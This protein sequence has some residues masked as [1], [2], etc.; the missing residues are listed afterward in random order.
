MNNPADDLSTPYCAGNPPAGFVKL[1]DH[2]AVPIYRFHLVRSGDPA[3]AEGRTAQTFYRARAFLADWTGRTRPDEPWLWSLALHTHD[4]ALRTAQMAA[5]RWEPSG[6]AAS[7]SELLRLQHALIP[8][9]ALAFERL[10][11]R[12]ADILALRLFGGL[13]AA[14]TAAVLGRSAQQ[15]ERSSQ[16][17]LAGL[18][19]SLAPERAQELA[20]D[21][22][23]LEAELLGLVERI[24]P[25]PAF[26]AALSGELRQPL[27]ARSPR[28]KPAARR[29]LP[30]GRS[31]RGYIW[32]PLVVAGV[33]LFVANIWSSPAR[34]GSTPPPTLAR[35]SNQTPR[36]IPVT[37]GFLEPASPAACQE[38]QGALEDTLH[39]KTDL[40]LESPF[41]DPIG[42]GEDRNG[43][44]C[45]IRASGS[46]S[47]F[48]GIDQTI[49]TI[50]PL[51]VG[52]GYQVDGQFGA[53]PACP[54]CFQFPNDVDG[55]GLLLDK[56]DGRAILAI[57]WR[58]DDVNLCPNGVSQKSCPLPP[59]AQTYSLRLD[60][61][62]DPARQALMTFF[63]R[64]QAGNTA[65]MDYLSEDLHHRVTSLAELNTLAGIPQSQL[66]A[67]EV[68]WRIR[69][70]SGEA[71]QLFVT[72]HSPQGTA[73]VFGRPLSRLAISMT[74]AAGS[75][76]IQDIWR[77]DLYQRSSDTAFIADAQGRIL[78]LSIDDGTVVPLTDANFYRPRPP[79]AG[80]SS[81]ASLVRLSPDG[82]WLAISTPTFAPENPDL[83]PT[84]A[85]TWLLSTGGGGPRQINAHP[86]RMAWSPQ[87]QMIAYISPSDAQAIY[88]YDVTTGGN[89]VLTRVGGQI[90][91]MAWSPNGKQL[92]VTYPMPAPAPGTN[93]PPGIDL[94]VLSV[95]SGGEDLMVEFPGADQSLPADPDLELSWTTSSSEV[96][97][98]PGKVAVNVDTHTVEPLVAQ[99]GSAFQFFQPSS[100]L[101]PAHGMTLLAPDETL[102]ANSYHGADPGGPSWV[103][104]HSLAVDPESSVAKAVIRHFGAV[105]AL[106][107][108]SDSRS[109]VVAGGATAPQPVWRMDSISGDLY[110]LTH[111][112]YFIGLRSDLQRRSLHL[113]PQAQVVN[114]AGD[115][116]NRVHRQVDFPFFHLRLEVPPGWQVTQPENA[117]GQGQISSIGFQDPLG[118]TSLEN[119]QMMI[120][121]SR[122]PLGVDLWDPAQKMM[123][124]SAGSSVWPIWEPFQVGGYPAFWL[125]HPLQTGG[126]L[127]I[128]IPLTDQ[129]ITI[130]KYPFNSLL[131]PQFE[132]ILKSITFY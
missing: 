85:G 35:A 80:S 125:T 13:T 27:P 54:T 129:T 63:Q 69:G 53:N 52:R 22:R 116:D 34:R 101:S 5:E 39:V 84:P 103:E 40:A 62:L 75:W 2:L 70:G 106:A 31:L 100:A 131:D 11:R 91:G 48:R 3:R 107:W 66:A 71:L 61:A 60:M 102:L 122:R 25:D 45:E 4:E 123:R 58:P 132:E 104:I 86:L 89:T 73:S 76:Q 15:I 64:W 88:V 65:A 94:S 50:I 32:V 108:T 119:S 98:L 38:L 120:E 113:A 130:S 82:K 42:V 83:N 72:I 23:Q 18:A 99:S 10:P 79:A 128:Q 110:E 115:G 1:I 93:T 111:S 118:I 43:T 114:L 67:A 105:A 26:F 19:E 24:Q 92:A 29:L 68:N 36:P 56:A 87:S 59:S 33:A 6:F 117:D 30:S 127:Q 90:R 121:I 20:L 44:G 21:P 77:V 7:E 109:L 55:K 78:A 112:A 95:S 57:G 51:L 126:P 46:G 96:W 28:S 97:F 14:Q 49:Q 9:I 74:P 81:P 8:P 12:Q 124:S 37:S 47:D 16:Q 17:G 41:V